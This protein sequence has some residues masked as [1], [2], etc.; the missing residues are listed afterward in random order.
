MCL[1]VGGGGGGGGFSAHCVVVESGLVG[2]LAV[3][4]TVSYF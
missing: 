4:K 3:Q 1:C 2:S